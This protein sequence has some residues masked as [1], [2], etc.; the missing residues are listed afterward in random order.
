MDTE[1]FLHPGEVIHCVP[2]AQVIYREFRQQ[3]PRQEHGQHDLTDTVN[4]GS[5]RWW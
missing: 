3:D 5:V 2:K 4:M 1:V